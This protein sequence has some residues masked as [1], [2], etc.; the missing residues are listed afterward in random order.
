MDG[1]KAANFTTMVASGSPFFLLCPVL[2]TCHLDEPF[3][4]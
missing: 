3:T 4:S 2:W 1:I